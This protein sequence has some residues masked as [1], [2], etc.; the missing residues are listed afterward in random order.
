MA[1]QN[2]LYLVNPRSPVPSYTG[3][4]AYA[5]HGFAPATLIADL[6]LPTVAALAPAHWRV[7]LGDEQCGAIDLAP[8]EPFV[9]LTGKVNQW[10]R[11]R[12]LAAHYRALGKVVVI[13]GSFASLSA[14]TV[15]PHCDVLVRGEL[16][17]IA[18][19]LFA[20]LERGVWRAEYEGA[21]ADLACSP[22]PR[23]DLY[24]LERAAMGSV[25]TSRG[26]P[27]ECEFCDV[28]VYVGRRQRHKPV[29][30]VLAELDALYA[31]GLRQVY[32][33]DDNL[34]VH[35]REARALMNAL[36]DWN[37]AR[38]DGPVRFLTQLSID[39]A[40]DPE[41]LALCADAGLTTAFI[42]VETPDPESLREAKK[43]QNLVDLVAA[44][45]VFSEHGVAVSAGLIAGFDHDD[46]STFERLAT[47]A[48]R[49]PVA[50]FTVSVL[51][52]PEGTPL[53]R[54]LAAAGRLA[55]DGG[56]AETI[57]SP[58]ATN[59]LPA[60]MTREALVAGVGQLA[61]DL[62]APEAFEARLTR[63]I[64]LFGRA[65]TPTVAPGA[66]STR[67]IDVESAELLAS[68]ARLGRAEAAMLGRVTRAARVCPAAWPGVAWQLG[69]YAH[70][71]HLLAW[72]D[73]AQGR[74]A[75]RRAS[76]TLPTGSP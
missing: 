51:V 47:F 22:A 57:A 72:A 39:L 24:P 35:R 14:D 41:L 75:S 18:A 55:T 52:A 70:A 29:A 59:I 48:A 40:R 13:G 12:A 64:A 6:A 36:G 15:R 46:P 17:P 56:A 26:C 23:W 9:G 60:Q 45:E 16:E 54:R 69:M 37:R 28:I 11:A 32:L 42:G 38:T 25:Q 68:I 27:F 73:S 10:P 43:R 5:A 7:R 53:A 44:L 65:H 30:S 67:A 61:R 20:D 21:P 8:P 3:G 49:T 50:H 74:T 34:T 71:R 4:E 66:P 33:A 19:T 58:L 1:T 63:H 62:Y 76:S 2:S 31:R